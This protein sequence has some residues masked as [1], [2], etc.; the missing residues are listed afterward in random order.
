MG[1]PL[2]WEYVLKMILEETI[3]KF[4]RDTINLLLE[5][6]GFSIKAK[7]YGAPRPEG[8][9]ADVEVVTDESIGHESYEYED[10]VGTGDVQETVKGY[11][12]IMVSVN[13]YR[14]NA[15]DNCRKVRTGLVRS[16]VQQLFK[17][18]NLGLIR[19]S[20]VRDIDEPL[21]EGWETRSQL[22]IFISAVGTDSEIVE[23]VNALTISGEF[24]ARGKSY[25]FDIEV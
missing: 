23:A 4:I 11:R 7:Q 17:D 19:R 12:E 1:I 9:Y 6:S 20:L 8:D 5:T 22:D 24:Q 10:D 3:N 2:F 14:D 18:A 21:D 15:K 16:K 25:N 13:F